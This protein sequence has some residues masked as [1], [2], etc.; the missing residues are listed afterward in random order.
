MND[1]A[2]SKSGPIKILVVD[3]NPAALY[4]TS[5]VLRSAG[6]EVREATTDRKSVV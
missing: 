4:A 5:R 1:A 2:T 3:D 6:Y